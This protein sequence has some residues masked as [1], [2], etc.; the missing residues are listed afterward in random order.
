MTRSRKACAATAEFDAAIIAGGAASRYGG[1]DKPLLENDGK[2]FLDRLGRELAPAANRFLAL[3]RPGRY[4]LAGWREVVDPVPGCGP[5]A[6]IVAALREAR[7]DWLFVVAADMPRFRRP[8]ADY[9]FG[10]C[11]PGVLAVTA[12]DRTGREHP[13][14]GFY[15]RRALP[16]LE[17]ALSGGRLRLRDLL[18][19]IE[20]LPA[21]LRHTVFPDAI[22]T[23]VNTPDDYAALA[24]PDTPGPPVIAV[25]GV[26]NSGKTTFLE[27]VIPHLVASGLRVGVLKHDG[28]DFNPDVPGT[29]SFRLREAGA[30][31]VAVYSRFRYL[32]TR[33][34]NEARPDE[35][36]PAFAGVDVVLLEGGKRSDF[37]KIEVLPL[38]G[39]MTVSSEDG[40][41]LA[42]VSGTDPKIPGVRFLARDDAGAASRFIADAIRRL[43]SRRL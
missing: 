23:N 43:Q 21:P 20:A 15:N 25:C 33:E 12:L 4:Q 2:T 19:E 18:D 22:V 11:R 32:M 40:T 31:A 1:I 30:E 8:L 38:T 13:L 29:D 16:A 36:L 7:S 14:C 27:Q 6:G 37:P 10:Y 26:K 34:W 41:L 5:L 42:V 17:Q 24:V 39:G 9:L 35:L 3:D 28:H